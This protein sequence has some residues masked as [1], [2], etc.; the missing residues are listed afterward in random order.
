MGQLLRPTATDGCPVYPKHLGCDVSDLCVLSND[1]DVNGR[2]LTGLEHTCTTAK[3]G[4][5]Q[6]SA[7]PSQL[8]F[9]GF[10]IFFN[11]F[12]FFLP[13]FMISHGFGAQIG[14]MT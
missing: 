8:I 10:V 5:F 2:L 4:R 7:N 12:K 6:K 11:G 9:G 1:P 13:F 3:T 14:Q